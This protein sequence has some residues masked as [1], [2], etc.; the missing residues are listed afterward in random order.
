MN[1]LPNRTERNGNYMF[2]NTIKM[3]S[4]SLA[5]SHICR[6]SLFLSIRCAYNVL[7]TQCNGLTTGAQTKQIEFRAREGS[8]RWESE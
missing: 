3:H 5:A 1:E 4:A 2:A 6:C 8:T 7:L